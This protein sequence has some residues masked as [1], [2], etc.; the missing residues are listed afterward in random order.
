MTSASSELHLKQLDVHRPKESDGY[1][2]CSA[3]GLDKPK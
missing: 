1:T 2:P 3:D